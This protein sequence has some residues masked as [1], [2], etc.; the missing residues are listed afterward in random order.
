MDGFGG[1]VLLYLFGVP[2][3]FKESAEAL[4]NGL[5]EKTK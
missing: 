5:K 2:E 4:S 1:K 3:E